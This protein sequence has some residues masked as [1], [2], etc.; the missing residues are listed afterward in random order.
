MV[1]RLRRTVFDNRRRYPKSD[2][3]SG[4]LPGVHGIANHPSITIFQKNLSIIDNHYTVRPL[5]E[6]HTHPNKRIFLNTANG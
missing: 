2:F 6:R 4:S 5:N 3:Q 1:K